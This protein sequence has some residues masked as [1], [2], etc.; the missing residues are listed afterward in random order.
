MGREVTSVEVDTSWILGPVLGQIPAPFCQIE[1]ADEGDGI[2][3]DNDLRMVRSADGV[4][5]VQAE[6]DS[7]TLP[8]AAAKE[9]NGFALQGENHR[10]VPD[11]DVSM[12]LA[13][14]RYEPVEKSSEIL[15]GD[16]RIR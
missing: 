6:I 7:R 5:P 3:D 8:P 14:A 12:E 10:V 15:R 11:Q 9:G 13:P 1:A 4:I 2:I 16:R